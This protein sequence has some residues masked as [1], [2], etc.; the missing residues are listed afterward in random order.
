MRFVVSLII[1][2]FSL[3][4]AAQAQSQMA[5][6]DGEQALTTTAEYQQDLAG[7][8]SKYAAQLETI[9]TE[10]SQIAELRDQLDNLPNTTSLIDR[11]QLAA[12]IATA[13][14]QL[15]SDIQ[16]EQQAY[17]ADLQSDRAGIQQ[18][19]ATV[20]AQYRTTNGYAQVVPR[21]TLPDGIVP[22]GWV[23]ITQSVVDAYNTA[24][25]A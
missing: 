4:G 24:Y 2:F 21:A 13:E 23:D 9:Q 1:G 16:T 19:L 22:D 7:L 10:R 15:R 18:Q 17:N 20:L 25:P 8:A 11:Q 14:V 5:V 3:A 6:F 12:S